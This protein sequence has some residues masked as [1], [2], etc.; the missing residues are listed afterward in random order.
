[1]PTKAEPITT[2][3]ADLLE[4]VAEAFSIAGDRCTRMAKLMRDGPGHDPQA[5]AVFDRARKVTDLANSNCMRLDWNVRLEL[6][7]RTV[8]G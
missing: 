4:Q 7:A 8:E 6:D 5:V 1:M 3:D 2:S